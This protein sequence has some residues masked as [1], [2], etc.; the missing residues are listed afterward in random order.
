MSKYI[1]RL[2]GYRAVED[3]EIVIDGITILAGDNG[4]GKSTLSRWLYYIVK[5]LSEYEVL[6]DREASRELRLILRRL[7]RAGLSFDDNSSEQKYVYSEMRNILNSETDI[8]CQLDKMFEFIE[9]YVK[10]IS[11]KIK[12][13]GMDSSV[14]K[15]MLTLFGL[16]DKVFSNTS[17]LVDAI[18]SKLLNDILKIRN[19]IKDKKNNR[20]SNTF[21]ELLPIS[22]EDSD[23]IKVQ[24]DFL[25]DGVKLIDNDGF[26]PVLNLDKVIYY[27][28]YE[29]M[30]YLNID[31]DFYNYLEKPSGKMTDQER[32]VFRVASQIIGGKLNLHDDTWSFNK[33]QLYYNRKD[34]LEIP[35]RQAATGLISFSYLV[36]L[37][38]N[39]YLRKGTLL[40][41]DEP[42]AHLHPKWIVEY[43]RILVM[44]QKYLDLKVVLSTHN[45]DMLAAIDAISK[46]ENI[47]DKVNF[48]FARKS[49][50]SEFKY[51]YEH[52]ES[53]GEIFNSFND[54]LSKIQAYGDE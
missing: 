8:F 37:L 27:K 25:E 11:I 9:N 30:D 44:L 6:I 47:A 31:S 18:N 19:E 36:R 52:Q 48:Y 49:N 4:T 32:I 53:I 51:V 23:D 39:G 45:P 46:K 41:I 10:L 21:M 38:E 5:V 54:A 13:N 50:E 16:E 26:S 40:I 34:G 28:T 1:Y 33:R 7:E 24:I 12:N 29:L 2:S 17:E 43:A 20:T 3:A 22:I 42:E 14:T 35:L 15:R